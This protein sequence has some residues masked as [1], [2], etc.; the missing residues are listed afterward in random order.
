MP[1][2]FHLLVKQLSD[3]GITEFM[4]KA[5][6]SYTKYRNI[7]YKRQG[8]VFQGIFKAVRVETDEQLVHLSRYIHLNPLVASLVSNLEHYLWSS[9][10]DYIIS[11][12]DPRI[13]K[14]EVLNFFNSPA[15]YQRFVLDHA[16]YAA[17]L[18]QL[19]HVVIEED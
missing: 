2:H 8:P 5:M 15:Q 14:E 17:I 10:K 3:G 4:R 1:N 6:H 18:E 7:K 11:D 13:A 12:G 19:K 16:D 9:Y